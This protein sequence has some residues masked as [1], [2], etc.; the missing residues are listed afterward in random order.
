MF[1]CTLTDR[2][3]TLDMVFPTC[4]SVSTSSGI[5]KDCSINIAYNKQIPL[6]QA[7]SLPGTRCRD[8]QALCSADPNFE[9]SFDAA[10][11]VS[12]RRGHRPRGWSRVLIS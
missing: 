3:G 6:C 7:T 8:P 9:F 11:D 2:D 1:G 10:S 5:G 4:A 12:G